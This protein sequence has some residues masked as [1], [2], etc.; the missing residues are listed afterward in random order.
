MFWRFLQWSLLSSLRH[1]W[2][3]SRSA[4]WVFLHQSSNFV[5]SSILWCS[6]LP[7]VVRGVFWVGKPL[8]TSVFRSSLSKFSYRL[9]VNRTS[10]RSMERVASPSPSSIFIV[11]LLIMS[12]SWM[13]IDLSRLDLWWMFGD[14][15]EFSCST[16]IRFPACHPSLTS[17]RSSIILPS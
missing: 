4:C 6:L 1:S 8:C 17:S 16:L 15:S 11:R 13:T 10:R 9:V 5:P 2:A 7:P 12:N 3:C 14:L